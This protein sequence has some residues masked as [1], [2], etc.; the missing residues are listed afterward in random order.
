MTSESPVRESFVHI[1]LPGETSFTLAGRFRVTRTPAGIAQ[2]EFVYGRSYLARP[3]AVELDPV[4]LTLGPDVRETVRL[5]GFFGAIRDAMPDDWGRRLIERQSNRSHLEEFDY[6][7][8]GE[9]DRAGALAFSAARSLPATK[10]EIPGIVNLGVLA[11]AVEA[12][13]RDEPHPQGETAKDLVFFGASMGGARPKTTVRD[14][15]DLWLAKFGRPDDRWDEPRVE[16][17]VLRLAAECGLRT[18]DSRIETFGDRAALLVRRFDRENGDAG[19][20]RW[21]LASGLTLLRAHESVTARE[22]WSYLLLA[23]EIRRA[24]VDPAADL[25]ELF[26]RMCFNAAVRNTDD[27]PRNHAI[28]ADRRGWCLSP[29]YDLTPTPTASREPPFLAMECGLEG[30]TASRQNLLSGVGRFLLRPSEAEAM[31]DSVFRKVGANWPEAMRDAGVTAANTRKI[32]SAFDHSWLLAA[33]RSG[34][35]D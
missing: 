16:H 2:G 21:R 15:D 23:D 5:E 4:E 18:A 17:A 24:S 31:L 32:A 20:L 34:D 28:I 29:A 26:G 14:G 11:D 10:A 12:V 7:Q 25:R 30:R 33:G 1:V 13:L 3:S 6:L 9:V 8:P 19:M 35:E 22:R 27:H